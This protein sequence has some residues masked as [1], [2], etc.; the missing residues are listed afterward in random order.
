M[1]SSGRQ[2]RPLTGSVILEA[3]RV[4]GIHEVQ[5]K[6]KHVTMTAWEGAE[7]GRKEEG[8]LRGED[9]GKVS[10]IKEESET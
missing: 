4:L 2:I 8:R 7:K 3:P 10:A 5:F 6:N 1:C 9:K